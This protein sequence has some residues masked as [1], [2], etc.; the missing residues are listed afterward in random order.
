MEEL[1]GTRV[2]LRPLATGDR[3]LLRRWFR[4]R[5]LRGFIGRQA[6]YRPGSEL[7]SGVPDV[8]FLILLRDSQRPIGVCGLFGI[9]F[10]ERTAEVGILLGEKDTW[11][12][13][14]G[15][16]ALR[17]LLDHARDGL[18]LSRIS[19]CVHAANTRAIRA[20]EKVGFVVERRLTLGRWLFGR[21]V[22]VLLMALPEPVATS[23][24]VT[25]GET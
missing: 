25:Q 11:G 18:G 23:T 16:E 15:P 1:R 9:S 17:V 3:P 2:V 6:A 21:G 7:A 19:L 14:Y 24:A 5:E 10:P 4:D 12:H 20:Y 8:R 22:E 13:G